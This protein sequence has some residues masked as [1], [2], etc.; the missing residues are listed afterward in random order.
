MRIVN[1]DMSSIEYSKTEKSQKLAALFCCNRSWGKS[2]GILGHVHYS[3]NK[4][5]YY[6]YML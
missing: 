2:V 5:Y 1:K 4:D 6:I 3:D